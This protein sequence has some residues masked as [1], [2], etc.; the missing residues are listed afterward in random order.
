MKMKIINENEIPI[1]E[2]VGTEKLRQIRVSG[3]CLYI[4]ED[5]RELTWSMIDRAVPRRFS[6]MPVTAEIPRRREEKG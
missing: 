6:R 3:A 4:E 1:W 2:E 5:V